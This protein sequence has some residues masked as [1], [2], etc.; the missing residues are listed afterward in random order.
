MWNRQND[1][2]RPKHSGRPVPMK[3]DLFK[4]A[5]EEV[6]EV[7]LLLKNVNQKNGQPVR[8]GIQALN[9]SSEKSLRNTAI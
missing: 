7:G 9:H 5:E 6:L 3:V 4:F 8:G 1:S 2:G